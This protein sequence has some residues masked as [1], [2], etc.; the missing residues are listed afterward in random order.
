[1]Q[2]YLEENTEFMTWQLHSSSLSPRIG[3]AP[4]ATGN[5]Y[6]GT[7]VT[8]TEHRTGELPVCHNSIE[9]LHRM[10]AGS[11]TALIYSA[12]V[13][14]IP[15][16]VPAHA[17]SYWSV[18]SRTSNSPQSGIALEVIMTP[19]RSRATFCDTLDSK[20]PYTT[21]YVLPVEIMFHIDN[22]SGLRALRNGQ[23]L[24]WNASCDSSSG[25]SMTISGGTLW[26]LTPASPLRTLYRFMS[27][28]SSEPLR[29]Q[30]T[31]SL[32]HVTSNQ[33]WTIKNQ[34]C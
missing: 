24:T 32:L 22:R 8:F 15:P 34:S 6:L 10:T 29:W 28:V 17:L 14:T 21:F 27:Q 25:S 9:G 33:P 16:V 1:M 19:L 31:L 23:Q 18:L 7:H 2:L 12:C 30:H 20:D 4:A 3:R 11:C 26:Y 13:T 5:K